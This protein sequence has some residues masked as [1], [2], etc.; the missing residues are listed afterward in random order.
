MAI[1]VKGYNPWNTPQAYGSLG[2]T[3]CQQYANV[4]GIY[5][6]D[7]STFYHNSYSPE[8]VNIDGGIQ[9]FSACYYNPI[10][11]ND[12]Y[13]TSDG[14]PPYTASFAIV[15]S[16]GD[17]YLHSPKYYVLLNQYNVAPYQTL[18]NKFSSWPALAGK[19]WKKVVLT[20]YI[21]SAI[22][23]TVI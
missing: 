10:D 9:S 22:S 13:R 21:L 12:R 11:T 1:Y 14:C 5:S 15:D 8:S 3:S 17:I 4:G 18:F 2:D 16:A 6:L 19:K 20:P 7:P 23:S